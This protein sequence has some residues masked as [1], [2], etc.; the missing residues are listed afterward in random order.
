MIFYVKDYFII[1]CCWFAQS[2][3]TLCDCMD[4]GMPG[5]A[6]LHHLPEPAQTR[7]HWVSDATQPSHP[8]SS[9]CPPAFNLSQHQ[10]LFQW[11]G[12]LHCIRWWKYWS[13][14][15]SINPSNEYL[16]LI[17]V[18]IDW[19]D[20]LAVQGTLRSLLQH[21]SSKSSILQCSTFFMVQPHIHIWLLGKP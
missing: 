12:S 2:C 15:F 8:L 4:Y 14:S 1:C 19:F 3:L 17:S 21:H 16:G 13:F 7:V 11:V 6:V 9:S 20:L 5:F 18:R 10:G